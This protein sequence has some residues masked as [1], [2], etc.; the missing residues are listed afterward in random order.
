M[1]INISAQILTILATDILQS[2][3]GNEAFLGYRIF[4]YNIRQGKCLSLIWLCILQSPFK[5]CVTQS[6][7]NLRHFFFKSHRF[8]RLVHFP[9]L[10]WY[11]K[12]QN[13][14]KSTP[15]KLNYCKIMS[16][17]ENWLGIRIWYTTKLILICTTITTNIV[18]SSKQQM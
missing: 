12:Q 2:Y 3:C 17:N 11:M 5:L 6:F 4:D 9:S 15:I 14:V 13:K 10:F 1:I 7:W 16:K 8:S 18:F